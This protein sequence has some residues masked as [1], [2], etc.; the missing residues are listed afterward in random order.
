MSATHCSN[1][2]A[3]TAHSAGTPEAVWL[4]ACNP[5]AGGC[6]HLVGCFETACDQFHGHTA[7]PGAISTKTTTAW[8]ERRKA[9]GLPLAA[10]WVDQDAE[11]A[12]ITPKPEQLP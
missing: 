1:C 6:G 2:A 8:H 3:I 11:I 7:A 5:E 9:A 10:P 12:V 4:M